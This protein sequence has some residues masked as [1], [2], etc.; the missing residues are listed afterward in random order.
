MVVACPPLG[1]SRMRK[2]GC[3]P[4]CGSRRGYAAGGGAAAADLVEF[5][6]CVA[7]ALASRG[8]VGAV[9]GWVRRSW[10]G[11]LGVG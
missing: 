3:R 4:R 1:G 9:A 11:C 7:A 10:P 6:A 8:P 2:C 5:G